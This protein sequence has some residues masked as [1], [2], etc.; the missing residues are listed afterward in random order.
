MSKSF[1]FSLLINPTSGEV[2]ELSQEE[3]QNWQP[4]QGILWLH[5]NFRSPAA[6]DWL[7]K[8]GLPA[9]DTQTL[10]AADTRPRVEV[11]ESRMLMTLRGINLNPDSAPEDMVA[12][13]LYAD[14][15]RVI[16]SSDRKVKTIGELAEHLL[17]GKGPT[18]P[19]TFVLDFCHRL[20][21]RKVNLIDDLEDRLSDI[22]EQVLQQ[23]SDN[24]RAQLAEIRRKVIAIRRYLAPQKEAFFKVINVTSLMTLDDRA[25]MRDIYNTLLRVI[26][27]LD[28]IRDR[29]VVTQEELANQLTEQLNKRLYFLSLITAI[30][31]PLGFLT[32]LLG[33]NIG[34]IPGVNDPRAFALFCLGLFGLILV[35][36]GLLY[37][38]HWIK[39]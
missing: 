3:I 11:D 30:F 26:E 5:M 32:G 34:G 4:D 23:T 9:A 17:A 10:L 29:A 28:A 16:T 15:H 20:T 8:A 13:R 25:H 24:P 31:L 2:N 12:V 19:G 39:K 33:V 21:L 27:D 6:R 36:I 38:F 14:Q 35:Q 18:S 22:E 7:A 37:R 1:V